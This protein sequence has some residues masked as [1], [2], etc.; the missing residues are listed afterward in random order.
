MGQLTEVPETSETLPYQSPQ[1]RARGTP[2]ITDDLYSVG[3]IIYESL[4]SKLPLSAGNIGVEPKQRVKLFNAIQTVG[5]GGTELLGNK[6]P[7]QNRA[8]EVWAVVPL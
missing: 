4:T 7:D 1:R 5:M 6:R 8:V 3:A 2:S